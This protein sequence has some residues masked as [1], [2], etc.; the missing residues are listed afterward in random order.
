MSW[1]TRFSPKSGD[2]INREIAF[3][4]AEQTEAN[5]ARGLSPEEA[6][7][8]ALIEFGGREQVRQTVREVHLSRLLEST[9]F[10][11]KAALRFMRKSPSFSMAVILTLAL[12]IGANSAVFSAIDAVVLRPLNFPDG[13]RM[14]YI[15]QQDVRGRNENDLVPPV[16]LEDWNRMASTFHGISG[17]FLED[18]SELSGPLPERVTDAL[19]APRFLQVLEVAPMLGRNFT[20]QEEHWAGPKAVIISYGYWKR[21][22]HGDPSAVGKTLHLGNAHYPVVGVMPSLFR[23]PNGDVDLWIPSAPDAPAGQGRDSGW[24][25]LIGRMKPGISL[26]QATADLTT[27]QSQLGKQFPKTDAEL[28]VATKPLKDTIVGTVRGSLWLLY[29]S[30][31]LLLMIACSN[32]AALLL[33]RTAEREREISLRFALGASRRVVVAQLLSEVLGLA[34]VGAAMGLGVAAGA[35]RGFHLLAKTL[36]RAEEIALNWRVAA[37]SLGCAVLTALLCGVFPALR[38]TRRALAA[39]LAGGSR[40]QVSTRNPVQWALVIIQVMLAV[41]LLVGAG[42]LVRSM[43]EIW[44]V[45]PGFDPRHVLTFEITGSW[46][47]VTDTKALVQ[48][49]ERTLDGLRALPGIQ[50]AATTSP[51]VMLPGV[52]WEYQQEFRIDG[53][54]D[55]HRKIMADTRWVS[56]GYFAVLRIPLLEGDVCRQSSTTKDVVVNRS[57]ANLYGGGAAALG[58]TLTLAAYNDFP[59]G[60]IVRGIVGDAREE[61]LQR[62]PLPIVYSCS[63]VP[64]P[65]PNYLVRTRGD[66]MQ[67]AEAVRRRIRQLEPS[68]SVYAVMPL[69]AHLD[70]SFSDNRLRTRLLSMF[71]L[72]AMSLACI[73]LYGTLSYL[74]RLRQREVGVRLALGALRSHIVG[75]FLLQGLRA[76]AVGCAAGLAL[77][78]GLSHFLAAMLYGVSAVDPATYSGV[79]LLILLVAA[80]A[81]FVPAV[82]AAWVEPVKVLREE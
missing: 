66:P 18:L 29:G 63:R 56:A 14:V 58:H 40:T 28:T 49:I 43:K 61:G 73:G 20:A 6:R 74:A 4:I 21:R 37:Y 13:D 11:L 17:Y 75:R 48:R 23:F 55:S 82:R 2:L 51:D 59:T 22:F 41:T 76:A 68:R 62:L 31:S 3:H 36:P 38:G 60:G 19:V 64:D 54:L 27:V 5:L 67:M 39:T 53:K 32:I 8:Q 10:N 15:A 46:D 12:A 33:A 70:E 44:Q 42:L 50:A 79:V 72:T 26:R 57:F 1:L 7:R 34:V 65:I 77:A 45:N 35:A 78:A 25:T 30:V 81:S 80:V 47:E 69:Q 16:R 52:P 9:M 71:A 24:F